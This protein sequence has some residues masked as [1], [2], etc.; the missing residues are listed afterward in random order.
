MSLPL[1]FK[2]Y[3]LFQQDLALSGGRVLKQANVIDGAVAKK[4]PASKKTKVVAQALLGKRHCQETDTA[5][6]TPRPT[7]CVKKLAKKGER[8]IHVISSQ[9]TGTTTPSVSPLGPVN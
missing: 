7:K 8:K 4:K 6:A 1:F 3:Q 9:Y 5:G 2:H